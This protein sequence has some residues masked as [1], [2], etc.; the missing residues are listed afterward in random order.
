MIA[1]NRQYLDNRDVQVEAWDAL[2]KNILTQE[3]YARIQAAYPD[4]LYTPNPFARL[5][6]FLLTLLAT[7]CLLGLFSLGTLGSEWGMA[8]LFI[9]FGLLCYGA[10]EFFIHVREMHE[11]GVD[12][13]LLWCAGGF[14]YIG[15][16]IAAEPAISDVGRSALVLLVA[17]VGVLRYAGPVT[18]L[19][20]YG[21]LLS[22]LF[23]ATGE[24]GPVARALLPFL[25]L[26]VSAGS[27]ILF[28]RMA[29]W[30]R[31]RHYRTCLIFLRV[32]TLVSFYGAGNYFVVQKVNNAITGSA[33]PASLDWL[34]WMLTAVIPVLYVI[35]G[36]RK[37]DR[38][39][40]WTGMILAAASIAT[41]RY[42]YHILPAEIMMVL[43][44]IVLIAGAY[45]LIRYLRVPRKDITSAPD[46][47]PVADSLP[48][49]GLV[50]AETLRVTAAPPDHT[51]VHFGGGSGGGGGAGGEF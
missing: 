16:G 41:F 3:E 5:G 8:V 27:Y 28:T 6:L 32:A 7:A 9:V 48:I 51:G 22:L 17:I 42:Y 25:M 18:S 21:A 11:A 24:W 50:L 37:K 26:G 1:Y 47:S 13:A 19:V 35:R 23:Y 45:F 49:E 15:I 36:L 33:A 14:I 34:W 30:H 43:G 4:K 2:Q 38:L 10:L 39:F 40:L 44:G 31:L 12:D 20:A 29:E 46:D